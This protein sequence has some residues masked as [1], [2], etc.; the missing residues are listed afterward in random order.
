M[1]TGH[2][3]IRRDPLMTGDIYRVSAAATPF[4]RS[5]IHK[6]QPRR[7]ATSLSLSL[8]LSLSC[9]VRIP[10]QPELR[11]RDTCTASGQVNTTDFQRLSKNARGR[12]H[13]RNK[14]D[15][16]RLDCAQ[17]TAVPRNNAAEES[18]LGHAR[19]F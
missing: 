8:S 10:I 11:G 12:K 7:G 14:R 4:L 2:L 9:R 6:G 1:G 18:I 13:Y 5:C 16:L 19:G 3:L 17:S 15:Y